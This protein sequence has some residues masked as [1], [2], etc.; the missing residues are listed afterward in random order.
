MNAWRKRF[1]KIKG[2]GLLH[3]VQHLQCTQLIISDVQGDDPAVIGS[4]LLV[5][6]EKQQHDHDDWLQSLVQQATQQ[7]EQYKPVATHVIGSN[8]I[9]LHA[10]VEEAGHQGVDHYLHDEFINGD[11]IEQGRVIGEYL[12]NAAA[13]VHAWGGETT[14]ELPEHPGLG[15]RNQSLA[16]S[17][18]AA[19]DGV[20]D[21]SVL[22][23]GTD[24]IDGNTPCAGAIVS[25]NSL[26]LTKQMGFDVDAELAKANAGTVLMAIDGL[27]KPGPTST[28]VMDVI[29]AYKR[30]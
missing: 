10:V 29:I 5:Q 22:A 19:I 16:L 23:A 27:F 12:R 15:G 6:S 24:G 25:G 30:S 9:A 11:A 14:V 2:G 4:G 7:T 1:S 3:Y 18:A 26:Q 8:A 17:L 21:L 28:N 13:G 20:N